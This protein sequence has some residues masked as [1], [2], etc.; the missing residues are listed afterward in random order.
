MRTDQDRVE[1]T[2]LDRDAG[3]QLKQEG[4]MLS[5]SCSGSGTQG[6]TR[7]IWLR[8]GASREACWGPSYFVLLRADLLDLVCQCACR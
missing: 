7:H 6:L 5:G 3:S 8:Y 1:V 2:P 4:G